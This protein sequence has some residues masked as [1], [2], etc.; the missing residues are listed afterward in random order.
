MKNNSPKDK[1]YTYWE[2]LNQNSLSEHTF[3]TYVNDCYKSKIEQLWDNE[4]FVFNSNETYAV[5]FYKDYDDSVSN[6]LKFGIPVIGQKMLLG[7][8]VG[9]ILSPTCTDDG[10]KS[11]YYVLVVPTTHLSDVCEIQAS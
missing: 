5:I 7:K 10:G 9:T 6:L 2:Y 11:G 4:P 3:D 1:K 8:V